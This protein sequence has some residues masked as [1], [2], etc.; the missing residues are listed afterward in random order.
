MLAVATVQNPD[1]NTRQI[2]TT[3][4]QDLLILEKNSG[5]HSKCMTLASAEKQVIAAANL[6]AKF[7]PVIL[8]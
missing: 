1:S 2:V 4:W 7:I 8:K 6:A 3:I 5:K